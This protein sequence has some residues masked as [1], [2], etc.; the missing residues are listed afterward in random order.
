LIGRRTFAL[1]L[2]LLIWWLP[3]GSVAQVAPQADKTPDITLW[4]AAGIVRLTH[5]VDPPPLALPDLSGRLV[6]L[7]QLRGQ[8]VL[9][10]FW[11]TW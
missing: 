11:A 1:L 8:V 4:N 3:E 7:R 6:D 2:A 9:V 5:P 10:Y